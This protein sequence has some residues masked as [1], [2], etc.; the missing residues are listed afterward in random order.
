EVEDVLYEHPKVLD[1]A[2]LGEPDE[3]W[4]EKVVAFVVKKDISL[5][6]DELEQFCKTSD[7][8]AP[9]KR[10]RAYYFVDALPRNASGKIQKFLLREQLKKQATGGTEKP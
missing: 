8:L 9:Y 7:R 2:V 4:G 5:T 10:P 3:L 6:A 1:A